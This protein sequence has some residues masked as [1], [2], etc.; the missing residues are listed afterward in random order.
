MA[1]SF[2]QLVSPLNQA[3]W[4]QY[5]LSA[6][7]GIGP[8]IQSPATGN[9]GQLQ[10]TGTILVQGPASAALSVVIL[11]AP[12]SGYDGNYNGNADSATPAYF[13]Y[14]LD[15]GQTFL[16]STQIS[17]AQANGTFTYAI[18]GTSL[19]VTFQDGSYT[20]AASG[21]FSFVVGETYAFTTFTPTFPV[22]NWAAIGVGNSLVQTDAQALSD[23]NLLV[24]QAIAGG[25][26]QS[27]LNPP[28]VNG[29]PTPPPDGWLDLLAQNFYN[30][31]RESGLQTQG[32]GVLTAAANAGPYTILPGQL[33]ASSANGLFNFTNITGGSLGQG[34]TL[35]V[36]WQAT[37]PGS[38]YNQVMSYGIGPSAF[39]LTSLLTPLA[40]VT[41][42]NPLQSSPTVSFAGSGSGTCA[43]TSGSGGP[44]NNYT[45]IIKVLQAGA[46]GTATLAYSLNGGATY[47]TP[48]TLESSVALGAS[49]MTASFSGTF[50]AGDTFSFSSN[51]ITQF[52]QDEQSSVSLAAQCQAQWATLAPNA[53]NGQYVVWAIAASPEVLG[54][55]VIADPVVP[56]QIDLTVF[57]YMSAAPS[58]VSAAAISAVQAYVTDRLGLCL[59]VLTSTVDLVTVETSAAYIICKSAYRS[60][61]QSAIQQLFNTYAATIPLNGLV[62]LSEIAA[63]IQQAPG[64]TG[65]DPLSSLALTAHDNS[66]PIPVNANGDVQLSTTQVATI[67]T[68]PLTSFRFV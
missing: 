51:W 60:T 18:P 28:V 23:L 43:V 29:V 39:W 20:T 15:G 44:A 22:T 40:G 12:S 48:E 58:P 37:D 1:L 35:Q 56:G 61:V 38:A 47:S 13:Q 59:S 41:L 17:V 66:G 33:I 16:P 42:T 27:W 36:T 19:S 25:F 68:P 10:G 9:G 11:I 14:S 3:S 32:V 7:Q 54:A 30:L 31:N 21:G 4:V 45:G 52:G 49:N 8:I 64:V 57:G 62:E 50:D 24:A 6:L 46:V 67:M 5:L 65:I 34:G 63:L 53:P 26:T 55:L 2:T